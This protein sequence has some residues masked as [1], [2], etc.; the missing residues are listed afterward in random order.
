MEIS[1][2]RLFHAFLTGATA[3]AAW[4]ALA[5][6]GQ[7]SSLEQLFR[8]PPA[9]A[10]PRVWWHW[11]NGN[12]TADAAA[13]DLAWL[14]R[15]GVAG[16][17][18]FD[19]NQKTPQ[20]VEKR[21]AY[22]TPEWREVLK[23]AASEAD[24]LGL[25][26]AITS[27]AG[28][29]LTGGPW[30]K[31]EDAM[32]KLVWTETQAR[33]GKRT[34]MRLPR[35]AGV[36][37][38][39]DGIPA[40][41]EASGADTGDHAPADFYRDIAVLAY[42]VASTPRLPE[43]EVKTSDGK[44]IDAA[45]LTDDNFQ[46]GLTLA[47]T[48]GH[49]APSIAFNYARPQ[50]VR[51]LTLFAPGGGPTIVSPGLR[52]RL[53]VSDDGAAWRQV[54]EV[55]LSDVPS[56]IS[57]APATA[58]HFRVVFA[59]APSAGA[60]SLQLPPGI[61]LA[62]L[63]AL[64]GAPDNGI[65]VNALRLLTDS[66][67]N[68]FEAKAGYHVAS[69]YYAL[70][71]LAP[72]VKGAAPSQ[73]VDLS[74]HMAADGTLDWTPPKGEW[75]IVRLG[76]SLT[77]KTNHPATA[78]A[79][80]LEVDKMDGAAVRRYF[81]EYFDMYRSAVGSD[82]FGRRGISALLNDSTEVGAFNWTP[83][84][85]SQFKR[86]RGYDPT[87]WLPALTGAVIGSARESNAFLYDYRRTI[88]DL[89][90]TEHYE[91][92]AKVAHENGLKIYGEA[93]ENGRPSLGDDI[94]LRSF[95]DYPMAAM[96][97]LPDG[98]E[99][100]SA[101]LYDLRGA[102]SVAHLY[103][104]NIA[105]AESLTSAFTPWGT[106]P[107]SLKATIDLEFVSGINR[108]VIASTVMQP[109]EDKKPGLSLGIFGQ[110]FNRHESWAD[111]AK[112][113]IDYISRNSLLLQQG[114]NV[115]DVA[116]FF[117]EE[118]PLT[119][120][121]QF[122]NAKDTPKTSAYD[123]VSFDALQNLLQNDGAE[124]VTKGGARYRLLYLGGTSRRMTVP[125]LRRIAALVEGGATVLGDAPE[126]SPSLADDTAEFAALVH[127]LWAG[128]VETQVG[129]GRVIAGKDVEAALRRI[130]VGADFHFTGGQA[131]SQIPFL[132][133]KLDDGDGYFLVNRN[134]KR[135]EIIE[136]RFRVT[137]KAPEMWRAETGEVEQLSYRTENGETIVPLT[138]APGDAMHILFRKP[139]AQA[140]AS[141]AKPPLVSVGEVAG[142]WT[143]VFQPGRGAPAS[144]RMTT[145]QPLEKNADP[146]IRYFSGIATYRTTFA[147]PR[148]WKPGRPLWLDFG[149][150]GEIAEVRVN[151]KA[152]GTA[153]H[154][155]YRL[156]VG[157]RLRKGSNELEVKVANLWVNRLIGDQ[158]KGANKVAYTAIP[159]YLPSAELRP[160][161]LIG[162]V[163]LLGEAR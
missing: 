115:A 161:G 143:V 39:F 27:S 94:R 114:R 86:L 136:A 34:K 42:P 62:A 129:K 71:G 97:Y 59:P 138:L 9:S 109:A 89:H 92:A 111:M 72:D 153:W 133:R 30:V 48:S 68:Q 18:M 60:P 57:F 124:L 55:P 78:E 144:T 79:T 147:A 1:R 66:K 154:A 110:Y 84:M 81:A 102:A 103:G 90:A 151:G 157:T 73:V 50:T 108:P 21:L 4:P 23:R 33:G 36:A 149:K 134:Q 13:K 22:M 45:A 85:V 8:D 95:T 135:S 2:K 146:G 58:R 93:L 47:K 70:D 67:I 74:S 112:P 83:A 87:P 52:P 3:L 17:Q 43:A 121:F 131:D 127:K 44:Q 96:W 61:D 31:P 76:W 162:P 24:R 113:W 128:G 19:A 104:Q 82:L 5:A 101:F 14:Q 29:S 132:H 126:S 122:E 26:F 148:D 125:A 119:A 91:V 12:I 137:G 54:A 100:R 150:V 69:D 141:V 53:E 105:A 20:I 10:R 6:D 35:P 51:G 107:A 40:P 41:K 155:P 106:S 88:G 49:E 15:I 123:F 75:R 139:T 77:G 120:L 64:G 145:L 116:Y 37:G 163:E 46:S 142:P 38:P 28:W 118:A 140:S 159:T 56:T 63:A 65:K 117:G 16:V 130:D 99:P 156:N 32:K 152:A 158:Q 98:G 160:S 7:A 80:G 25:E 11:M